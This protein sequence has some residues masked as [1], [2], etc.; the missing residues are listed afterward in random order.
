MELGLPISAA[1]NETWQL[2]KIFFSTIKIKIEK[3]DEVKNAESG[4][5]LE[6]FKS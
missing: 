2:K 1:R 4:K 6:S 5:P 3:E